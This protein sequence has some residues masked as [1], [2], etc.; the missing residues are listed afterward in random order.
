MSLADIKDL[1]IVFFVGLAVGWVLRE[2]TK[3]SAKT[4]TN[5][6]EWEFIKDERGRTRGIK[7]HR[8]AQED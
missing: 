3:A 5:I 4:Y 8:N 1:L 2:T 6:E 7:V